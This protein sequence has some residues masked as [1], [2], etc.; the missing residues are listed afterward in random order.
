M[1]EFL[2][3][4]SFK[5]NGLKIMLVI[6]KSELTVKKNNQIQAMFNSIA[7]RYDLLNRL[8]SI[9]Y[10]RY[11]RKIAVREFELFENKKYLDMATGTADIALEIAKKHPKPSQIIGM[12]FS[13][14]M[15]KL[16]HQKISTRNI[17]KTIK[18]I[19]GAA[20]NI[21]LKD[22]TFDGAI[23]AFGVRNFLDTQQGIREMYRILKPNGKIVILEFSFPKK[24][25]LSRNYRCYFEKI[26]P[27]V[28][29]IFSGHKKAYSYLPA[30][31]ANFPQGEAFNEI[32]KRSGFKNVSFKP[33]TLGIVT[34]YTG[35]KNA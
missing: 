35:K 30:S 3:R 5:F 14:S 8:L 18:L 15:L 1:L 22:H 4:R 7:P 13:I 28:G 31:V 32:L 19:P 33:L 23:S 26:L 20:E 2:Q 9:G 12:D 21:P 17:G 16:G 10:D 24:G 27:L 6:E 29:R 11:W 34:L 25:L